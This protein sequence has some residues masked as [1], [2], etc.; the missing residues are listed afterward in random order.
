MKRLLLEMSIRLSAISNISGII[1]TLGKH[2]LIARFRGKD[3]TDD[4]W[5]DF[6]VPAAKLDLVV[7]TTG[8]GDTF[9]GY[10]VTLLA[11][12]SQ[13]LFSE[14]PSPSSMIKCELDAV[15]ESLERS[16]LAS[17]IAC[18]RPGAMVSIPRISDLPQVQV[19]KFTKLS[20]KDSSII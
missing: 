6:T 13:H 14:L 12:R 11:S 8:A 16:T 20:M 9:V 5:T 17:A 18:T 3:D 7:D 10:F 2:G 1:I 4:E 19:N 15:R